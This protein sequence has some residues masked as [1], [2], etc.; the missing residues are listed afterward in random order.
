MKLAGIE[1]D[2]ATSNAA[3][4]LAPTLLRKPIK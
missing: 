4:L 2:G 3:E 1:G